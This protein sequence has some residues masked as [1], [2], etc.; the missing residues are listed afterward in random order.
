M[1]LT[2]TSAE[3]SANVAAG[4]FPGRL[5]AKTGLAGFDL[6]TEAQWECACRAGT[7]TALNNGRDLSSEKGAC[8]NLNE[9]GRYCENSNHTTQ[10]AGGKRPNAWDLYDMH[11]NVLELCR[12]WQGD[13][14][15]DAIVPVGLSSGRYRVSRGGTWANYAL[16]CRSA[17]RGVSAHGNRDSY[18]GFRLALA[19]VQ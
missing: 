10:A 7:T 3:P 2:T 9:V 13:C 1:F 17:D 4:S 5:R 11:G 15:G 14:S 6:P 18:S 8:L 19:P 12:D 16:G